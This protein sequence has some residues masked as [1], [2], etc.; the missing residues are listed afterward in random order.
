VIMKRDTDCFADEV[1]IDFPSVGPFTARVRDAFLAG[2]APDLAQTLKAEVWLSSDEAHRGAIV[3]VEVFVRTTC[4]R[5]GGSGDLL[6]SR[7]LRVIV[8]PRVTDGSCFHFR[9]HAFQESSVQVEV[10]VAVMES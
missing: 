8:P 2:G 4:A 3:P 6:V 10:K 9:L 5:C 1:A 7:R